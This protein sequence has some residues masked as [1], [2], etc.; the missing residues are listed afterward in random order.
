MVS[1]FQLN[2]RFM[3]IELLKAKKKFLI[4]YKLFITYSLNPGYV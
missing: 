1:I 2:K 4:S 3:R